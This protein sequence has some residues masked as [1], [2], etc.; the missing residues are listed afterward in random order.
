MTIPPLSLDSTAVG[1]ARSMSDGNAKFG[2]VYLNS[3]KSN[4]PIYIAF[5][6]IVILLLRK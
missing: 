5:G 1:K 3:N 2:D 6:V 4:I